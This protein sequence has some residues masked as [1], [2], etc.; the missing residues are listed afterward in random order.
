MTRVSFSKPPIKD[1][2]FEEVSPRRDT[3][4]YFP[5][6]GG[7]YEI[8]PGFIPLGQDLGN[9]PAD[10]QV[11]QFDSNFNT[12]HR[13]K[14]RA[15]SESLDKYFQTR[16]FPP[17]TI[18]A[19]NRFIIERLLQEHPNRFWMDHAADGP[20]VLHCAPNGATLRYPQN[21]ISVEENDAEPSY[22]SL[23]DALA[24]QVQEDLCVICRRPDGTDWLAAVHLC[25]PSH[26]AAGDKIGRAFNQ[27]HAPVAGMAGLNRN[28]KTLVRAMVERDPFVRFSWGLGTDARLNHH[29]EHP[30]GVDP[31]HWAGRSFD[32]V[33]PRLFLR[34]ERQVIWGFPK[35]QAALFTIRTYFTSCDRLAPDQQLALAAAIQS[36]T[37]ASL[38]YKGL[39]QSRNQI[40]HWLQER[41]NHP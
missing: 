13:V 20:I 30:P 27:V 22:I 28:A 7:R 39:A 21:R 18:A 8:K 23:F 40:L 10:A 12:Y 38:A 5:L 14:M 9:G 17:A 36:M 34:I 32:P 26:W 6:A 24:C 37:P 35:H 3:P 16:D 1:P 4:C 2:L 25:F 11:F 41:A 29:P 31:V 15:R 33:K 19:I